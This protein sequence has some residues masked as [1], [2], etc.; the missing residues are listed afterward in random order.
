MKEAQESLAQHQK[1]LIELQT[2]ITKDLTD[3]R[4]GGASTL[5][6][7]TDLSKLSPRVRTAAAGIT[8]ELNRVR[9]QYAKILAMTKQNEAMEQQKK[10]EE[11]DAKDLEATLPILQELVSAAEG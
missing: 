10:A 2:V 1:T 5:S 9:A 7:V 6:L 4:K 3:A 11:N 8:T